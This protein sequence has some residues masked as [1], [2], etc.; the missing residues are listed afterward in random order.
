MTGFWRACSGVFDTKHQW[1]RQGL[2]VGEAHLVGESNIFNVKYI[3]HECGLPSI[4][5]RRQVGTF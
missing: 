4:C 1:R 2:M 5:R 3:I